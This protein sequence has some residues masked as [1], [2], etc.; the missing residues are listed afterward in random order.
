MADDP[1]PEAPDCICP[2]RWRSFGVLHGVSMGRGWVR[3]STDPRCRSH[4]P[5]PDD[6]GGNLMALHFAP[7]INGEPVGLVVIQRLEDRD[8]REPEVYDYR[9][10]VDGDQ[11]GEATFRHRY[12]DGALVCIRRALQAI[13]SEERP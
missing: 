5:T 8:G 2:Y 11:R 1:G 4:Q 9:V 12:G 3:M 13:E 6:T 10:R 7:L